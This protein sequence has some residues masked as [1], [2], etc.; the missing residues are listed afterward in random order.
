MIN[1]IILA[2]GKGTRMKST[3][4]KVCHRLLGD[5]MI[6]HVI[7]NLEEAGIVNNVLVVGYK[8]DDVKKVIRTKNIK[9]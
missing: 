2:A 8:A 5:E 7:A 4:P 6:N 9:S 3:M 1:S